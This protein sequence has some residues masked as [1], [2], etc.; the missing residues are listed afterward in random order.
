MKEFAFLLLFISVSCA[1]VNERI[2][3]NIYIS[4]V[5]KELKA[6]SALH[7]IEELTYPD[8]EITINDIKYTLSSVKA[9][10]VFFNSFMPVA[11]VVNQNDLTL[12]LYYKLPDEPTISPYHSIYTAYLIS[13]EKSYPI[14]FE[15]ESDYFKFTKS[16]ELYK[17]DNFYVPKGSCEFVFIP[18][19]AKNLDTNSPYTEE[20]MKNIVKEFLSNYQKTMIDIF[21][22]AITGY[23][24]SLPLEELGQNIYVQTSGVSEEVYFDLTLEKMPYYQDIAESDGFVILERKGT[25]NQKNSTEKYIPENVDNFQ[26]FNLH[27]DIYHNLISQNLFGFDFEQ[28]NNPATLYQLTAAYLKKVAKLDSTVSDETQ[29]KIEAQMFNAS[30]D[31]P[32]P[33]VG[34]VKMLISFISKEEHRTVFEFNAA[35]KFAFIPTLFQSGLNFVLLGKNIEL[36]EINPEPGYKILDNDLLIEWIQNTYLC[37]L[38]KN[39]YNLFEVPLDLSYYFNS[40]DLSWEYLEDGYLSIKKN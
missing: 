1:F 23:Y 10:A 40:N 18:L 24:K 33:M 4:K 2:P 35:F 20:L 9:K 22:K 8:F 5:R 30:F 31:N 7:S 37:A 19:K 27:S 38:G 11:S 13:N 6:I 16:Y 28:S 39:E 3:L 36:Y 21:N 12:Q 34:D 26:R 32:S 14:E 29:L 15:V 25:L 17:E